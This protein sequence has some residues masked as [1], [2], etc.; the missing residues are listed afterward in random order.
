MS[1]FGQKKTAGLSKIYV[2]CP[3]GNFEKI[4]LFINFIAKMI[5]GF[6]EL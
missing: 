3:E 5:S 4:F 2:S 6:S 1:K